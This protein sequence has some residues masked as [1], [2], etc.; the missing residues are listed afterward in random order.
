MVGA[1][2]RVVAPAGVAGEGNWIG[3]G[4]ERQAMNEQSEEDHG[5]V[6]QLGNLLL[7]LSRHSTQLVFIISIATQMLNCPGQVIPNQHHL[8]PTRPDSLTD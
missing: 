7:S 6:T 5:W 1:H 2:C 4:G 8:E 3:A